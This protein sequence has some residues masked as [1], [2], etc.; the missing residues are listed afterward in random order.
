MKPK[1]VLR[2][3]F[4]LLEAYA[5]TWFTEEQ[6]DRAIAALDHGDIPGLHL[7]QPL[8]SEQPSART[9]PLHS[10]APDPSTAKP[11]PIGKAGSSNYLQ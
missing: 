6:R 2:E 7:V 1:A 10:Q 8:S 5:P 4:D 9:E 11:R 3:L